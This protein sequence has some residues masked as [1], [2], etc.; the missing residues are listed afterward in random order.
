MLSLSLPRQSFSKPFLLERDERERKRER[1]KR[2][3]RER[4]RGLSED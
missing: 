1:K 4:E 2:T 3:K